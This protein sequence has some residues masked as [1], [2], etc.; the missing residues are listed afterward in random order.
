MSSEP[1]P[2]LAACMQDKGAVLGGP[3]RTRTPQRVKWGKF[4][5]LGAVV[6]V[7]QAADSARVQRAGF[8][9]AR[10]FVA[11]R[12]ARNLI[13]FQGKPGIWRT[14]YNLLRGRKSGDAIGFL[15]WGLRGLSLLCERMPLE[16]AG[17]CFSCRFLDVAVIVAGFVNRHLCPA[18]SSPCA[19]TKKSSDTKKYLFCL[20]TVEASV[21]VVPSHRPS[22]PS[23]LGE[24]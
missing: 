24:V 17:M 7:C 12:S 10:A 1:Q 3:A 22:K 2:Q 13:A 6:S 15:C 8:L 5:P 21:Q 18:L 4:A 11:P 20:G 14:Q 16:Y 9:L 19:F 23:W